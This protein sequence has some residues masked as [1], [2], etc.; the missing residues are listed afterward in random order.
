MDF[1]PA[2]YIQSLLLSAWVH[3]V[4]V[5]GVSELKHPGLRY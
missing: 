4:V 1:E 3:H 2:L 5:P